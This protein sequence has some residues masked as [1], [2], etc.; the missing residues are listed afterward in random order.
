[1]VAG[2]NDQANKEIGYTPGGVSG[3]GAKPSAFKKLVLI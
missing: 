2:H 3:S 1:M